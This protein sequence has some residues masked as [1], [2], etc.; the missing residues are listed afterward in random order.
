M[1]GADEPITGERPSTWECNELEVV[2]DKGDKTGD[3]D[4]SF[5]SPP[6]KETNERVQVKAKFSSPL[7]TI[8]RYRR[9]IT[10]DFYK[11][12]SELQK[13]QKKRM[14]RANSEN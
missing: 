14:K 10:R 13:V 6:G 7:E 12:L 5:G 9:A 11:A 4:K 2:V 3:T 1:I 8:L